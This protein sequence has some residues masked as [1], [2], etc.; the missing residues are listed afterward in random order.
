M[1]VQGEDEM[2]QVTIIH[3]PVKQIDN[4]GEKWQQHKKHF[5]PVVVHKVIDHVL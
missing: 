2:W 5:V 4:E 3:P 1:E